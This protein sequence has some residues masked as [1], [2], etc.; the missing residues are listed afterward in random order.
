MSADIRTGLALDLTLSEDYY[1]ASTGIFKDQ[2]GYNRDASGIFTAFSTDKYG[3]SSGSMLFTGS[4]YVECSSS[5]TLWN[6]TIPMTVSITTRLDAYTDRYPLVFILKSELPTG[7]VLF[8]NTSSAG[9]RAI[10]FGSNTNFVRLHTSEDISS[11]LLTWKHVVIVYDGV[12]RQDPSSYKLYVDTEEQDLTGASSYQVV[13]ARNIIGYGGWSTYY[14]RGA[15]GSIKVFQNRAF[16]QTEINAL[17]NDLKP[18]IIT[19][20]IMK[21]LIA[22]WPLDGTSYNYN[23]RRYTDKTPYSNHAYNDVIYGASLGYDRFGRANGST[24]FDPDS[25]LKASKGYTGREYFIS[26][27]AKPHDIGPT[28]QYI[29]DGSVL[30]NRAVILGFQVGNWN[31]WDGAYPTG[32]PGDTQIPADQDIWQHIAYGTDGTKVYGYKNGV[33]VV[34]ETGT[35]ESDDETGFSIGRGG[36]YS[37]KLCYDGNLAD[38]R[39]YNRVLNEN[40]VSLIRDS[41]RPK[42]K[43]N[44]LKKGLILDLPLTNT[45]LH[46]ETVGSEVVYD[47][48]PYSVTAT[49]SGSIIGSEYTYF[50]GSTNKIENSTPNTIEDINTSNFTISY[51]VYVEDDYAENPFNWGGVCIGPAYT[52]GYN[53][54][55]GRWLS[56]YDA[57]N[58]IYSYIL[59]VND[60]SANEWYHILATIDRENKEVKVYKNGEYLANDIWTLDL[61]ISDLTFRCG[62]GSFG[63]TKGRISNIKIHKRILSDT[64]IEYLYDLGRMNNKVKIY[65]A[66]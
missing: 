58:G 60:C 65:G 66:S 23:T 53:L 52:V 39:I 47:R 21:G 33:K 43:F 4:Q 19:G 55:P 32:D 2:S 38:V 26:F 10:S 18:K 42:I 37:L 57:S 12:D 40:E 48:T 16:D 64:E 31:I 15:I 17:Y 46:D 1:D 28:W 9:Y 50:N 20:N 25:W 30:N 45:Y 59:F 7:I 11:E 61:P 3:K 5:H 63:Y 27:W 34:E 22:H 35:W 62:L 41:Y 6:S 36:A 49:N 54:T 8:Y 14:N 44:S 56:G 13:Q 29:F 51:W 24:E